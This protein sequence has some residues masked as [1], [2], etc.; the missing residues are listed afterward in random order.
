MTF[1]LKIND[2]GRW[3]WRSFASTRGFII[4]PYEMEK[5]DLAKGYRRMMRR[6]IRPLY[7]GPIE[8]RPLHVITNENPNNSS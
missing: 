2:G 7:M 6:R 1:H 3:L 5:H 4:N 8:R